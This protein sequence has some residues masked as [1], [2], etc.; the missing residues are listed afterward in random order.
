MNYYALSPADFTMLLQSVV[1]LNLG[2]LGV[3]V[4]IILGAG[5]FFYLFSVKP[6]QA[7]LEKQEKE[8]I[9]LKRDTEERTTLMEEKLSTLLNAQVEDLSLAV[10]SSQANIKEYQV[11]STEKLDQVIEKVNDTVKVIK[12]DFDKMRREFD[13]LVLE[14]K[15]E[16]HYMWAGNETYSNAIELL[17]DFM[18]AQ[19]EKSIH[20]VSNE[21]WL[22]RVQN[23]LEKIGKYVHSDKQDIQK[24]LD[25]LLD[26]IT[27]SHTLRLN[28]KKRIEEVFL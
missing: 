4:T 24:R 7:S 21:L 27:D 26:K 9:Q 22:V 19:N 8:L 28:V 12:G 11:K 5:G 3:C 13:V 6:F 20:I 1:T 16:E 14:T 2:Y 10:V 15:W 18:E 17:I 25:L 23:V